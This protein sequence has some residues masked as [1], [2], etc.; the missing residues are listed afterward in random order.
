M[1]NLTTRILT[2]L[3]AA[4]FI[5]FVTFQ[6]G[7]YF[8][9]LILILALKGQHELY[10][11]VRAG[12]Q[13]PLESV[14]LVMGAVVVLRH[15]IPAWT[16]ILIAAGI[17]I[18]LIELFR[19]QDSPINALSS[20]LFGV[21]Y[22]ALLLSYLLEIRLI[23]TVWFTPENAFYLTVT[24]FLLIWATDTFAYFTG[25]AIG[26]TPLFKRISPKKTW[27][28]SAGGAIGAIA[29]GFGL[30]TLWFPML[31]YVD[32]AVIGIICGVVSQFGDL[33][34]SMFKRSVN[35]KD[36]GTILPGHG[37]V[38]DRFDSMLVAAPLVFLYLETFADI[39]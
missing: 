12:G 35:I 6:G 8:T 39:W 29:I 23:E 19:K 13:K 24:L 25:K 20:T 3:A 21:F 10:N 11:M 18:M 9:G 15:H 5:V 36:S 31:S 38:L 28:G 7:I 2:A 34:E 4:P 14:G 1:S 37:G 16:A 22:P 33:I 32:M 27:E 30:K 26:K 17:L